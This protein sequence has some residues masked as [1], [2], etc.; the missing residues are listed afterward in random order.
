MENKKPAT[1]KGTGKRTATLSP[2]G[3]PLKGGKP[4]DRRKRKPKELTDPPPQK[5]KKKKS[6]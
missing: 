2:Q 3:G 6:K 4:S 5:P 1:S